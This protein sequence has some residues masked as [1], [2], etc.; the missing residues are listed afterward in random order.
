MA[1]LGPLEQGPRSRFQREHERARHQSVKTVDQG[2]LQWTLHS[3]GRVPS[4]W[5][6]DTGPER[7][8]CVPSALVTYALSSGLSVCSLA[9]PVAGGASVSSP[10]LAPCGCD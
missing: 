5:G 4:T 7:R 1:E 6:A 9:G 3:A 8:G 10:G 2:L